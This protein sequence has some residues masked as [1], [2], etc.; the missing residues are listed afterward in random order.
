[1][2]QNLFNFRLFPKGDPLN[3]FIEKNMPTVE[4]Y[5]DSLVKV[6]DPED[7]LQ[8]NKYMELTQ[9]TKPVILISLHEISMT[10]KMLLQNLDA[11][12]TEKEDPLKMILNDLGE[13]PPDIDKADDREIQLT[14]VNRF[15]VDVEGNFSSFT[16]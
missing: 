5:F 11:L 8:V 14:L 1:V 6:D 16:K 4:H 12:A 9:K 2:L 3:S 13:G 7:H 15:K 10:H